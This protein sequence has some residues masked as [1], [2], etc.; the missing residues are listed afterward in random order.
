MFRTLAKFAVNVQ[1]DAVMNRL[2]EPLYSNKR[3]TSRLFS[4]RFQILG[5]HKVSAERHPFFAPVEPALFDKQ[6]NFLKRHYLV[7]DLEELVERSRVGDVPERAVAI[8]FDDGYADNYH[9]AFP[10]LKKYGLTATIF[11]ATGAIDNAEVL[12]HD[13]I[14]DAFRY[15][16]RT[17]VRTGREDVKELALERHS[18]LERSLTA[19]LRRAKELYGE[20]R[21]RFIADIEQALEPARP[22]TPC[23]LTWNQIREMHAAGIRMGSHTVTHPILSRLPQNQLLRELYDSRQQIFECLRV[24]IRMFAYPNGG[25]SDYNENVKRVLKECG[26]LLAVTARRGFNSA[27]GD[28]YELKRGLPWQREIELFRFNF[29]LQR[30]GLRV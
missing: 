14:F 22:S 2:L 24:P 28:P 12:W 1:A 15:A 5:Y 23:M 6:M 19:A 20:E 9:Y 10:I 26:Y 16:R 8:T 17:R 13:R 7:M 4:R 30:H 27:F 25:A 3:G 11:V 18:E 29:F 21:A